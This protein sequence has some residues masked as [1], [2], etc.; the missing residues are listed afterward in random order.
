[1]MKLQSISFDFFQRVGRSM[2]AVVLILP[3]VSILMGLGGVLLNPNVHEI[4]PFLSNNGFQVTGELMQRAGQVV[5]NN[6]P[7]LFAVAIAI[8]WTGAGMAGF[9]SL[10]AFFIL[11]TVLGSLID[12]TD[13]KINEKMLGTELGIETMQTGVFGGILIGF[14]TAYLY[15]KFHRTKL[16]DAISLFS[17]ERL[18]PIVASFAAIGVAVLFYFIWPLVGMGILALGEY[19]ATHTNPVVVGLYGGIEKLLIPFGLHHIYNTPL[20]FTEIGGSYEALEGAPYCGRS[21]C[22][23][24]SSD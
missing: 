3:L 6:L 22:L 10:I 18:V 8:T 7:V 9:S 5:F 14:L 11:H 19:V 15:N 2:M 12:I 16:P 21:K 4:L 24:R 20:L 13:L 1:M 23:Y 17:G